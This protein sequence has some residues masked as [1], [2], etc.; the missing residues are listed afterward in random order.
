MIKTKKRVPHL[1]LKK[2]REIIGSNGEP[3]TQRQFAAMVG[4]SLP[5][6]KAVE[7]G[8]VPMTD[9][10]AR[11][12]EIATGAVFVW[13]HYRQNGTTLEYAPNGKVWSIWREIDAN[14][15]LLSSG[16]DFTKITFER[17]RRFY[18]SNAEAAAMA[19]KEAV[20]LIEE[21]F[22]AAAKPGLAGAKHRLP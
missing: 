8:Q 13:P 9:K 18:G 10:L 20:P 21:M 19:I 6:I 14:N 15:R 16:R 1:G 11:N 4:V 2:L 17:H 22:R 5:L 3:M 7:T 12:V